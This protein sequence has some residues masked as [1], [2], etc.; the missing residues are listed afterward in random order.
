QEIE[1]KI[2]SNLF[3]LELKSSSY[4]K[5]EIIDKIKEFIDRCDN[6][7]LIK[8]FIK[9]YGKCLRNINNNEHIN[10]GVCNICAAFYS[11]NDECKHIFHNKYKILREVRD[12]LSKENFN[13]K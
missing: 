3:F 10:I 6:T 5:M 4:S 7:L 8:R 2:E 11:L 1:E 9:A 13:V 12:K